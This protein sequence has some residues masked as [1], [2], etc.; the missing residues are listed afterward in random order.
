[1]NSAITT[2]KK[3]INAVAKIR[4]LERTGGL[5]YTW[6]WKLSAQ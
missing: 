3:L 2:E 4:G 5:P 6:V 1:L